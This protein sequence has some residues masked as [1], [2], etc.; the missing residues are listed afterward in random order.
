MELLADFAQ[1]YSISLI[2]RLLGV[3]M[4]RERDLLNWSHRMVKMYELSVSDDNATAAYDAAARF[5]DYALDLLE[6]R[7]RYP[8]DDLLTRLASVG[9]NGERLSDAE[10]VSTIVV[11]LNAGHEATVN[12]LG[13]C[14]LRSCTFPRSGRGCA[15]AR[16]YRRL[17]WRS[18]SDGIRRSSSSSAWCSP[19]G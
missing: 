2:C 16:C 7:R 15:M 6:E 12:A 1:P 5:R 9:V 3:P 19:M 4:G 18:S 13:N 8:A 10:I 17:R 14:L 11:L